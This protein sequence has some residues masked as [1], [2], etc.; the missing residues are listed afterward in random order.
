[1]P[2][3]VK[4]STGGHDPGEIRPHPTGRA[5]DQTNPKKN[6]DDNDLPPRQLLKS[7]DDCHRQEDDDEIGNSV[8][9]AR[10]KEMNALIEAVL[11][12]VRK[13]PIGGQRPKKVRVEFFSSGE[14]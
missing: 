3:P 6:V 14:S 10:H 9:C 1:V 5:C 2:G 4:V 11:R 8:N 12:F 7:E 13:R